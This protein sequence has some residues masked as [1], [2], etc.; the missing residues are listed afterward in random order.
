[1]AKKWHVAKK[2]AQQ[3]G[4]GVAAL[5]TCARRKRRRETASCVSG[6]A[7]G[8]GAAAYDIIIDGGVSIIW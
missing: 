4:I 1:V 8:I 7:A 6:G 3:R 5:K 2:L